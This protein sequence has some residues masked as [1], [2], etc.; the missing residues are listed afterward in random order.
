MHTYA[1]LH[2]KTRVQVITNNPL[3]GGAHV[4]L[5]DWRVSD[6][7]VLA[8]NDLQQTQSIHGQVYHHLAIA[9][10]LLLQS[11]FRNPGI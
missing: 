7:F 10:Q 2:R 5:S 9:Y 6:S 4:T 11:E 8:T 3:V 1:Q